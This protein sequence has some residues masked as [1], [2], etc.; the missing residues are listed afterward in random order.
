MARV[1]AH[2]GQ[3]DPLGLVPEPACHG[4]DPET[5][6]R[7]RRHA[8]ADQPRKGTGIGRRLAFED[9]RAALFDDAHRGL[10]LQ[11][12]QTDR[13]SLT[14]LPGPG[15]QPPRLLNVRKV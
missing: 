9:N 7:D 1:D 14:S 5:D 8:L 3:V 13:S 11:Y 12:V 10:F 2:D 4:A 15:K 6:T